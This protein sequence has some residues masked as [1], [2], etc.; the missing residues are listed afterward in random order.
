MKECKRH[1]HP[2]CMEPV[3]EG[4]LGKAQWIHG[5]NISTMQEA[6]KIEMGKSPARSIRKM[7]GGV[8]PNA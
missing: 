3:Q 7:K 8:P 2:V 1:N 6:P 4:T 5:I